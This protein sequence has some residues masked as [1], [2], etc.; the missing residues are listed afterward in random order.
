[1]DRAR[2]IGEAQVNLNRVRARRNAL[3]AQLLA[4][5]TYLPL[6]AYK[7][8]VG[9][10][11]AIDRVQRILGRSFDLDDIEHLIGLKPLKDD[12]KSPP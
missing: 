4:D 3:L 8:Q 10:M 11:R 9:E 12:E 7:R 1:V 6:S 2:A 5:H